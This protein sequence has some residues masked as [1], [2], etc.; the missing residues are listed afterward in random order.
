MDRCSSSQRHWTSSL[1]GLTEQP[2][3]PQRAGS[4]ACCE[5]S[6]HWRDRLECLVRERSCLSSETLPPDL[7]ARGRLRAAVI[8]A[9]YRQMDLLRQCSTTDPTA[10]S[11]SHRR[12][13][14]D[15]PQIRDEQRTG[16]SSNGVVSNVPVKS[17]LTLPNILRRSGRRTLLGIR[18]H[19][20]D[21]T[22]RAITGR[23][24]FHAAVRA[25]LGHCLVP[26]FA[27][28]AGSKRVR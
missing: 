4:L 26:D 3:T 25:L 11:A 24:R 22:N 14:S 21:T 1:S 15:V 16:R 12:E 17:P 28:E 2:P 13:W 8:A 27:E 20:G 9:A 5:R 23:C 7:A 6:R 19:R 18:E 10:A